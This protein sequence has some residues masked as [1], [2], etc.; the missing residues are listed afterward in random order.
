MADEMAIVA[1][2][3]NQLFKADGS[4]LSNIMLT[5]SINQSGYIDRMIAR[6]QMTDAVSAK[7]PI[8]P[9]LHLLKTTP[10]DKFACQ[11]LYQEINGSL[12]HLAV[13]SH[14]NISIAVSQLLQFMQEPSETHLKAV[15]HVL[16]YLKGTRNSLLPMDA[17]KNFVFLDTLTQIGERM[18]MIENQLL[19]IYT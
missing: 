1:Y 9:S 13:F 5:I 7:V 12:N 18:R 6:F 16:H 3:I 17:L 14:P 10:L 19:V 8:D 2:L 15:R 11:E 4:V